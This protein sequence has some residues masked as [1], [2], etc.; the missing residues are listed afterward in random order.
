MFIDKL[1]TKQ[2]DTRAL[3]LLLAHSGRR[4]RLL[5]S[6]RRAERKIN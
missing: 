4:L 3:S 2:R 6:A 1:L 5:V